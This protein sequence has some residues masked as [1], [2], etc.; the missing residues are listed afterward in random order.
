MNSRK[1]ENRENDKNICRK[2]EDRIEKWK[3]YLSSLLFLPG[4]IVL[5][6]VVFS[7]KQQVNIY[8]VGTSSKIDNKCKAK[9]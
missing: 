3:A 2:N 8:Q 6:I 1:V 5:D 9:K 4:E 7:E